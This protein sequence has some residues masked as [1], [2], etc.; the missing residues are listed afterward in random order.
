[1]DGVELG[2][3][4]QILVIAG[5]ALNAQVIGKLARCLGGP[6]ATPVTSIL[7]RRRNAS[8]WTRPI[9]PMPKIATFNFFIAFPRGHQ[10]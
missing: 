2:I 9:K 6:P 4:Q 5:G 10:V 1:M 3:G 7:P 8:V